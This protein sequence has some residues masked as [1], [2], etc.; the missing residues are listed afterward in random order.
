MGLVKN[1]GRTIVA[2]ALYG[3]A[4]PAG[5][6][7][8]QTAADRVAIVGVQPAGPLTPDR[9]VR[10]TVVADVTLVSAPEAR[11]EL[12]FNTANAFRTETADER[13]FEAGTRRLQLS[14]EVTPRDW[15]RLPGFAAM[16]MLQPVAPLSVFQPLARDMYQFPV[17]PAELSPAIYADSFAALDPAIRLKILKEIAGSTSNLD[18]AEI[19]TLIPSALRDRDPLIRIAAL[20]AVDSRTQASDMLSVRFARSQGVV[21]PI[22]RAPTPEAWKGNGDELR[23]HLHSEIAALAR[24]DSD[25]NVRVAAVTAIHDM[26][27]LRQPDAYEAAIPPLFSEIYKTDRSANV[28][29]AVV[30]LLTQSSSDHTDLRETLKAA[31]SDPSPDVRRMAA[32]ALQRLHPGLRPRLRYTDVGEAISVGLT[33]PDPQNRA[34]ALA[35]VEFAHE[36]ARELLSVLQRMMSSD[37]DP[38]IRAHAKRI[39]DLMN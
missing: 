2:V 38:T 6:L 9:P 12:A 18:V 3:A 39:A 1:L 31:F 7:A 14:A 26:F 27:R 25:E 4:W 20:E 30:R 23:A 35:A 17:R 15:G 29:S 5:A 32:V 19:V 34:A 24:G 10:I 36:D 22:Q 8:Q 28:R 13:P 33:D 37:P 16:V 21:P 11:V